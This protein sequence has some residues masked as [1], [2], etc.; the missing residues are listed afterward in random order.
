MFRKNNAMAKIRGFLKSTVNFLWML[1]LSVGVVAGLWGGYQVLTKGL[2]VTN[3]TDLIPWGLWI[4]IDLSSIALSAGAFSLCALVYLVGL[5]QYEPVA[6]TATFIGFIGYSMAMLCL[7]MDIGRPDRFWHG[8]VFWNVHS[9]LWEVTMC[10]GLYFSVLMA[11]TLP[12][13]AEMDW[14]K[15]VFP[16]LSAKIQGIHHFSPFLA[17]LGL[18]FS[19][20]HQSSLGATYGVLQSR[21]AWYRPTLALIFIYSAVLGGISLTIFASM[22]SSRLSEK[23]KINDKIL[24]PLTRALGWGL[25]GYLY[26]RFWDTFALTYNYQPGRSES[27]TMLT[28]GALSFNFWILEILLGAIIPIFIFMKKKWRENESLRMFALAMVVVGVIAY[29]WDTNMVGQMIVLTY[30]PREIQTLYTQYTPSLIEILVG[31]GVVSY[32]FMAF[33]IGVR[34]FKV[35][36]HTLVHKEEHDHVAEPE[37][38]MQPVPVPSGASD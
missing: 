17:I 26:F 29:R 12:I 9:V 32:G 5:K 23:A 38:E 37:R 25:M 7:F 27:L 13:I 31:I 6:R 18:S 21:P 36:D 4:G 22:I 19:L 33:T 20:L 28:K 11:E 24:N 3:L 35:V 30:L 2:V 14:I 34:F 16:K 15:R 1:F 10:V 8:F